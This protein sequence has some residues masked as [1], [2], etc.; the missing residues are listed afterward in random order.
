MDMD[1]RYSDYLQH[2]LQT[3]LHL[4]NG[5]GMGTVLAPAVALTHAAKCAK[6][7]WRAHSWGNQ[8][9][10][11]SSSHSN[12]HAL[13]VLPPLPLSPR[14]C[15][16]LRRELPLL[17][18]GAAPQAASIRREEGARA[19]WASPLRR[20]PTAGP[21]LHALR[22]RAPS[23]TRYDGGIPS[24]RVRCRRGRRGGSSSETST[25]LPSPSIR[26]RRRVGGSAARSATRKR[27][28]PATAC[29]W[30]RGR[31]PSLT[32]VVKPSRAAS[33]ADGDLPCPSPA[34][35]SRAE[36]RAVEF[37]P[38]WA[39]E[40]GA[41]RARSTL[42]RAFS[43]A[44]ACDP[45]A[46]SSAYGGGGEAGPDAVTPGG[47][48]STTVSRLREGDGERCWRGYSFAARDSPPSCCISVSFADAQWELA[49]DCLRYRP[50][51]V[52]LLAF[53]T[54][55]TLAPSGSAPSSPPRLR[56]RSSSG[57]R[58][59]TPAQTTTTSQAAAQRGTGERGMA[60]QVPPAPAPGKYQSLFLFCELK[61]FSRWIRFDRGC[62]AAGRGS[63]RFLVLVKS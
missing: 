18:P 33:Q 57:W 53:S 15:R 36:Q 30:I 25:S 28:T 6:P 37:P 11:L 14:P 12:R 19:E 32:C 44:A 5:E 61:I 35:S 9:L 1:C 50:L 63:R 23:S 3:S 52:S 42:P 29:R 59:R 27:S 38:R 54:T 39:G 16:S 41:A 2:M 24:I 43:I 22:R 48:G 46:R 47:R 45:P 55:S 31:L 4:Q 51:L 58:R 21:F 8:T 60:R 56:G 62:V 17:S 10:S 34:S 7:H 40:A 49:A 20:A 13:V 26:Q